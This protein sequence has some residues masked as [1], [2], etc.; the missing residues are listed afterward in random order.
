MENHMAVFELI[1]RQSFV[2]CK[3]SGDWSQQVG[4]PDVCGQQHLSTYDSPRR[5]QELEHKTGLNPWRLPQQ[6]EF[7]AVMWKK[8]EE[9]PFKPW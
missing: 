5:T 1:I 3:R 4:G 2:Q 7:P 6:S 9:N 8:S